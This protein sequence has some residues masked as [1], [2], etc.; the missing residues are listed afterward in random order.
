MLLRALDDPFTYIVMGRST[1]GIKVER[2]ILDNRFFH[3]MLINE[4]LHPYFQMPSS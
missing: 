4:F 3:H 1:K 2:P